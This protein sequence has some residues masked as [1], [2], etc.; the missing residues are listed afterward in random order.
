MLITHSW[1]LQKFLR[2][3]CD[4]YLSKATLNTKVKLPNLGTSYD[5]SFMTL[6]PSNVITQFVRKFFCKVA[7]NFKNFFSPLRNT[8]EEFIISS[9]LL[10]TRIKNI[11]EYKNLEICLKNLL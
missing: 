3:S 8:F 5:H 6:V 1:S 7:K 2:A 11:S 10:Y 9:P 4:H